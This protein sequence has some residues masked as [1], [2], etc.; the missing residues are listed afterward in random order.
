MTKKQ[1]SKEYEQ[2]KGGTDNYATEWTR[3]AWERRFIKKKYT[4]F[5]K[6]CDYFIDKGEFS[7]GL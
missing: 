1:F 4:A 2:L 3:E 7:T 5:I 6:V